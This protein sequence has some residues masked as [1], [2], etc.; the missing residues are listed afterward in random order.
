MRTVGTAVALWITVASAGAQELVQ[1]PSTA[2]LERQ[3]I[4]KREELAKLTAE[5]EHLADL[6]MNHHLGITTDIDARCELTAE[7]RLR[8]PGELEKELA[9]SQ[10]AVSKASVY[11]DKLQAQLRLRRDTVAG[12]PVPKNTEPEWSP[13]VTLGPPRTD[14]QPGTEESAEM[15]LPRSEPSPPRHTP[16]REAAAQGAPTLIRGTVDPAL[17]GVALFMS[18]DY[19]KARVELE[20]VTA[21]EDPALLHLFYLARCYE[22]LDDITRADSLFLQIE[23]LDEKREAGGRWARTARTARQHMNWVRDHGGW[24]APALKKR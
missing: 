21:N 4:G 1:R 20:K 14:D 16:V 8:P 12:Q 7:E 9:I 2:I 18:G 17:L 24:K 13:P 23:A 15:P 11:Q 6:L 3:L 10:D 22:Q 19:E 5:S